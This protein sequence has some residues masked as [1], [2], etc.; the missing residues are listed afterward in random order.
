VPAWLVK[1]ISGASLRSSGVLL[2]SSL[3]LFRYC[4]ALFVVEIQ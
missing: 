4:R 1:K 2:R 3:A